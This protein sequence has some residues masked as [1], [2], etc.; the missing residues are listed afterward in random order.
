[1]IFVKDGDTIPVE[2]KVESPAIKRQ[3]FYQLTGAI[4]HLL[5]K[6]GEVYTVEFDL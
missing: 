6:N 5:D 4:V 3:K 1:M 2:L